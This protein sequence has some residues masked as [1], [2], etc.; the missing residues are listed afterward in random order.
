MKFFNTLYKKLQ[1]LD[2][3]SDAD[4]TIYKRNGYGYRISSNNYI[5]TKRMEKHYLNTDIVTFKEGENRYLSF[6]F[7]DNFIVIG[8]LHKISIDN[9][10][11]KKEKN[12]EQTIRKSIIDSPSD[13]KKF[14]IFICVLFSIDFNKFYAIYL[15]NTMNN[16]HN[17]PF[18]TYPYLSE[19]TTK[20][21]ITP[22]YLEHRLIF[23]MI[24]NPPK[25]Y[26]QD[27]LNN[28]I[29]YNNQSIRFI[30]NRTIILIEKLSNFSIQMG[31]DIVHV[32]QLRDNYINDI[33][34]EQT[35]NDISIVRNTAILHYTE[36]I[37]N[38][39]VSSYSLFIRQVL[40][41]ISCNIYDNIT[42]SDIQD[43]FFIS[44]THL[45]RKF[46]DEVGT[47]IG[48]YIQKQKILVAKVLLL[49]KMSPHQVSKKLQFSD[50]SYFIKL[51][52][53]HTK[54]TPLQFQKQNEN[55]FEKNIHYKNQFLLQN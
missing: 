1:I 4:I 46:K 45:R 55:F 52:K 6:P 15:Q 25:L 18:K 41:Y 38:I 22:Y 21:L 47:S 2:T 27:F 53:K 49:S 29:I 50:L 28:F 36:I 51:F 37:H 40:Q 33:E 8:P 11:L 43:Y 30:K 10:F 54:M 26:E 12:L 24:H 44:N 23:L 35:T 14:I 34:N 42:V 19:D 13:L 20:S 32:L 9:N 5:T 39:S 48:S 7:K 17:V 16:Q 31:A 3:V